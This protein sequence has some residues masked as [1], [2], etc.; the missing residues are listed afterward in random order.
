MKAI[1]LLFVI[2]LIPLFSSYQPVVN[3][4]F[5]VK[6]II[7]DPG[8]G[9]SDPGAVSGK[10]QEKDIALDISLKLGKMISDSFPDIKVIY[11][12]KKDVFVELFHRAEIANKANANLFICI[13]CNFCTA[14]SAY[15]TE[16]FTMGVHKNNANLEVA[17]RENSVILLENDYQKNYDGFDPNSPEANIIFSL[18]QNA[19]INQ[20]LSFASKVESKFKNVAKRYSRGVKQAGFLVLWKTAMPSILIE[21]GFISNPN[22]K[23]FMVS[24]DGKNKLSEAIYHA[25]REYKK[26]IERSND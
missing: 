6:T 11:T 14:S 4:K 22:E 24:D 16:T 9:G 3:S 15:G 21:T 23:T 20:S 17:K 18:Y 8:H 26:E 1:R 5:R 2:L 12:R 7:I 10:I 13:H 19:Y 25:F